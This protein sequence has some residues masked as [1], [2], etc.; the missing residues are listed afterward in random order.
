MFDFFNKFRKTKDE[1]YLSCRHL[2]G[3]I[4]FMHGAVRTCCSN[5]KCI[6][7]FEN[8][9]GEPIDWKKVHKQR[10]EVIKNCKKGI[11]PQ[12]CNGCVDLETKVWENNPLITELYLNYWDHCNCGCVYC[13]AGGHATFLQTEKTKSKYYSVLEYLKKLYK[14]N[15]IS[16]DVHVEMVGG[17]LTVLDEADDIINLCIDNG[18]R[19][20]AF[21]SSCVFYSN[22]IERTLKEGIS[23]NMDFSL[24]CGSREL[25]QK[26]K[27]IDAF[28]QVVENVKRYLSVSEK[29]KD[30]IVAKYIIVDGLN[31][32]VEEVEKWITLMHRI[33]IKNAKIEVN[34][35]RFFPEFHHKDPTVPPHY[36]DI[37]NHYKKRIE[38]LGIKDHCWEFSRRVLEEG[39]I[40]KGYQ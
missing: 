39:G 25:Y 9:K 13:V 33:G 38:E 34:F 24:D 12:N 23:M 6:T 28:D 31:D 5:K 14:N 40:P 15:M 37:Y 27:R 1:E 29:A 18:V 17:D 35:K 26:I 36:Y 2:H 16:K 32:N 4:T 11:I 10:K 22:G 30:S 7:F 20:M 8:Y 21:H 3:G 19:E